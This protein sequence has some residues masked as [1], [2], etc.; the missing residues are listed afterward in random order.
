[1]IRHLGL[2]LF[3]GTLLAV[4]PA[5]AGQ[6]TVNFHNGAWP[7]SSPPYNNVVGGSGSGI[8]LIDVTGAPTTATLSYSSAST[9]AYDGF[10][11]P[12][13]ASPEFNTLY[14][15]GVF[16]SDVDGE[17]VIDLTNIPYAH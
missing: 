16:G 2:A 13:T 8:A 17:I 3:L 12:S 14:S 6:I 15:G 1:M 9:D 11:T 10:T 5:G 7:L 4:S